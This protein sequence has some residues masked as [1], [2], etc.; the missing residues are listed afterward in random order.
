M[1]EGPVVITRRLS[2]PENKKDE[3]E[4]GIPLFELSNSPFLPFFCNFLG[5]RDENGTFWIINQLLMGTRDD[6]HL[7]ILSIF[8]PPPPSFLLVFPLTDHNLK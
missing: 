4:K 1:V 3:K 2:H 5:K 8:P 7:F 6:H